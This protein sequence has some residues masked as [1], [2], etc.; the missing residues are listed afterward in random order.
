MFMLAA[1]LL[2]AISA[3]TE[4]HSDAV[5]SLLAGKPID[6]RRL[7]FDP[8]S[9]AQTDA[10]VFTDAF[11]GDCINNDCRAN[12]PSCQGCIDAF[13]AGQKSLCLVNGWNS[14]T[15]SCLTLPRTEDSCKGY[16][17]DFSSSY[18]YCWCGANSDC[19]GASGASPTSAPVTNEPTSA[20]TSPPTGSNFNE[21]GWNRRY[22]RLTEKLPQ[23]ICGKANKN[24]GLGANSE[25][26]IETSLDDEETQVLEVCC[27]VLAEL[28]SSSKYGGYDWAEL[29]TRCP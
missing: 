23:R 7:G 21:K 2:V 26:W 28:K 4:I 27:S 14:G 20:P 18:G 25:L 15:W 19:P 5:N 17:M 24:G 10:S 3:T 22:T 11:T 13:A 9:D 6:R 8:D 1:A 29:D 16:G 12:P